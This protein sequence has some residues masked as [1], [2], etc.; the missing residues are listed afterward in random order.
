M[1]ACVDER[2]DARQAEEISDAL[3]AAPVLAV[4]FAGPHSAAAI[5]AVRRRHG[6]NLAAG[7]WGVQ[8][9]AGAGS[10][11]AAG[12]TFVISPVWNEDVLQLC[13]LAGVLAI[14]TV[15]ATSDLH[16]ASDLSCPICRI[17]VQRIATDGVP[18]KLSDAA[19]PHLLATGWTTDEELAIAARSGAVLAEMIVPLQPQAD[20]IR[21][22]SP[23][24]DLGRRIAR[25]VRSDR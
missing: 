14:P 2:A 11:L 18:A 19:R 13:L 21:R 5:A 15:R 8:D 4:A 9:Q 20:V 10:A 17:A 22:P 23:A 24:P 7:A 12:A 16:R 3:L 6:T 25:H 1:I